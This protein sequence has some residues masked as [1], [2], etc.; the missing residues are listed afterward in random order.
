MNS[1]MSL[2]P[3]KKCGKELHYPSQLHTVMKSTFEPSG[4]HKCCKCLG[5]EYTSCFK[6]FLTRTID[7]YKPHLGYYNQQ[8]AYNHF[9]TTL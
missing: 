5:H 6:P 2:N 8:I 9:H 1:Y 3:C 4:G 7:E